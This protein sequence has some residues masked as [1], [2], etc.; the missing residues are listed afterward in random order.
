M[1]C[2]HC[3]L[4]L[5]TH[6]HCSLPVGT[7]AINLIPDG[8]ITLPPNDF[9]KESQQC[10][11]Q[12]TIRGAYD[13]FTLPEPSDTFSILVGIQR[14]SC[15][16]TGGQPGVLLGLPDADLSLDCNKSKWKV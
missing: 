4:K 11:S 6:C 15:Q 16:G 8:P 2:Q 13:G 10:S 7:A 5:S 14:A 12:Q 3:A 1:P 9:G